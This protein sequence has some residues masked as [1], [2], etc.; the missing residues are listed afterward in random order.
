M[1]T[2]H[3]NSDGKDKYEF[4]E[5]IGEGLSSFVYMVTEKNTNC[6][7]A[8]KKL[9]VN[10]IFNKEIEIH[11]NLNHKN[12]VKL[13]SYFTEE[14]TYLILE[15]CSVNLFDFRARYPLEKVPE[16]E[17]MSIFNQIVEGLG[18]LHDLNIAHMDIKPENVGLCNDQWKLMD[19]GFSDYERTFS[20]IIV[21][22][23]PDFWAPELIDSDVKE[24]SGKCVDIW[25]AGILL[26]EMLTGKA[27]FSD[28]SSSKICKNIVG[29]IVPEIKINISSETQ[30]LIDGMLEKNPDLRFSID[31][32]R[33]Y[34]KYTEFKN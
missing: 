16:K 1:Y 9:R 17:T 5:K 26:Y 25:A 21:H 15:L 6:N 22:G 4:G 30:K 12:I 14:N 32:I 2:Q 3:K 10:E 8:A 20:T 11:K 18:Y 31:Y 28:V 34:L 13:I 24:Y 23:T 27:P 33:H 7:Y 29:N 19:F